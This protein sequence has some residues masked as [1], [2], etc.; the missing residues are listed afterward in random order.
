MKNTPWYSQFWLLF[1]MF[2]PF[3]AIV[4]SITGLIL[5]FKYVDPLVNKKWYQEGI[6]VNEFIKKDLFAKH[7]NINIT[8]VQNCK[9]EKIYIYIKSNNSKLIEAS[10][11]LILE[12]EHP[13]N[14]DLDI[15][16]NLKKNNYGFYDG[17]LLNSIDGYRN[18]VLFQKDYKWRMTSQV[19]FPMKTPLIFGHDN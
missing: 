16:I 15:T 11:C 17:T 18:F 1:V 19:R 8:V 13:I 7:L 9:N 6:D 12:L 10:D 3:C 4:F 2:L 14:P 5:A